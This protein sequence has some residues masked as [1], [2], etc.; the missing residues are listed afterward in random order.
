M[1]F[2]L[3]Q[4]GT[5]PPETLL[6]LDNLTTNL[7]GFLGSQHNDDGSHKDIT[8]NALELQ[9]A[10]VGVWFDLPY[11][12]TRFQTEGIGVWTVNQSNIVYLRAMRIGEL[13][14]VAFGIEGSTITVDTSTLNILLPEFTCLQTRQTT[15]MSVFYVNSIAAWTDIAG[16]TNGLTSVAAYAQPPVVAG[17][18]TRTL[19][20][21]DRFG[22]V[23]ASYAQ[24]AISA[25]F[26][27]WGGCWFP[28]TP[29][30]DGTTYSF[31]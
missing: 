20:S 24:F 5:L 12:A 13:V 25:D 29:N 14:Y 2:G 3:T 6:E 31:S 7:Q 28:V 1:S 10:Q 23:N 21:I 19:L 9:G 17:G 26:N 16:G 8:T 30:N 22:P 18:K 4:R 15:G 11:S 27:I